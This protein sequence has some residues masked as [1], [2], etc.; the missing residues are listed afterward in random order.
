MK[1]ELHLVYGPKRRKRFLLSFFL[2]LFGTLGLLRHWDEKL[3]HAASGPMAREVDTGLLFLVLF[4]LILGFYTLIAT[5]KRAHTLTIGDSGLCIR[6]LYRTRSVSWE[7][8]GPFTLVFSNWRGQEKLFSATAPI[9]VGSGKRQKRVALLNMFEVPLSTVLEAVEHHRR[10]GPAEYRGQ[11]NVIASPIGVR[12]FR[13]A[14]MTT[15]LICVLIGVFALEDQLAVTPTAAGFTPSVDTLIALGGLNWR[16]I[17]S[18]QLFRLVIAPLLHTGPAHLVGNVLMLA[19][20]G[21]GL[22]RSIGRAWTFTIFAGGALAGCGMS[23]LLASPS[24]VVAVGAS[25][26]VLAMVVA[27]F[28]I[29]YRM[30][31]SRYRLF[32]QNWSVLT[33]IPA[34]IPLSSNA[35]GPHI[36]YGGHLGGGLFG[37][38]IGILLVRSWRENDPMPRFRKFASLMTMAGL[39]C[40]AASGVSTM[41]YYGRYLSAKADCMPSGEVPRT[42]TETFANATRLATA[43]PRDP[44]V[45]LYTSELKYLQGDTHGAEQELRT[46]LSLAVANPFRAT[47]A[48]VNTLRA[49]LAIVLVAAH[50]GRSE[51]AYDIAREACAAQSAAEATHLLA[52]LRELYLCA[53][54]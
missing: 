3:A 46:G 33:A 28:V 30:P 38:A 14:W 17:R 42:P 20:A 32:A 37:L 24:V 22:E 7:T 1:T 36:D 23:L 49:N 41:I 40:F 53:E 29:G 16:L 18:G 35:D 52:Q 39:L 15:A 11:E 5:L 21:Y 44:A 26:G 47:S 19:L 9:V 8:L 12:G 43:Y 13:F 2:I 6:G 10:G 50:D 54:H 48:T 27:L 34:L 45:Y 51:E 25:C 31:R 4:Y